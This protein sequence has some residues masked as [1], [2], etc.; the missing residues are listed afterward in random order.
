M[1]VRAIEMGC[2]VRKRRMKV[3]EI[4]RSR[5]AI[6]TL[7]ARV[8]SLTHHVESLISKSDNGAVAATNF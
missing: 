1:G 4:G 3:V 7:T 6:V 8:T 5:T 2:S